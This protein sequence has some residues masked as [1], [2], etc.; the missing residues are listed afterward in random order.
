MPT[1][2]SFKVDTS[3]AVIVLMVPPTEKINRQTGEILTDRDTGA[4]LMTLGVTVADE[5]EANLYT[6]NVPATGIPEGL[7]VGMPVAVTGLRAR[8]WENTF[9]GEKRWGLTFRAVAVTPLVPAASA[10]AEG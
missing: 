8:A 3:T 7:A 9:N 5:G 6:V 10:A 1:M 2:P 4:K